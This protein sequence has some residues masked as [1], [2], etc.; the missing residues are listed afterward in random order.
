MRDQSI[1]D[2]VMLALKGYEWVRENHGSLFDRGT[3]DSFY[4]R[5]PD[6]HY[7]GVGGE[8]GKRHT[9]YLAEE[10]AEYMAGFEY[11]E[12]HGDKKNYN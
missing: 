6:P 11:N 1:E 3:A 12:A 4:H 7:G 5:R 8:S 2:K 10:V 9:V